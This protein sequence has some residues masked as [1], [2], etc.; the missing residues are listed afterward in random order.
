MLKVFLKFLKRAVSRKYSN[1]WFRFTSE[2]KAEQENYHNEAK[3]IH[4]IKCCAL[5]SLVEI[6]KVCAFIYPI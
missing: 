6:L 4:C 2:I 3:S 1:I 5:W